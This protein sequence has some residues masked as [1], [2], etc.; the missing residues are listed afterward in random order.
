MLNE[1]QSYLLGFCKH[2]CGNEL[3]N[4]EDWLKPKWDGFN[5]QCDCE[6][7]VDPE[8]QEIDAEM[9]EIVERINKSTQR[10]NELSRKGDV[11]IKL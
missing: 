2:G 1:F 9:D 6:V 11:W 5:T 10:I 4:N 8:L 3:W 7:E